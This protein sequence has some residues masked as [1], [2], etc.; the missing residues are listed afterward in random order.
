MRLIS[1]FPAGLRSWILALSSVLLLLAAA[2]G[3]GQRPPDFEVTLY[4]GTQFRLSDQI[5]ESS[6]VLN[7]WYPTCPP[8]REEMPSLQ[9]A[10]THLQDE[11]VRFLGL[12][13]PQGFDTEQDAKDFIDELGLTFD[14]ATD[15]RASIALDYELEVYPKTYFINKSGR[16]STSR[17]STLDTE[18]IIRL[19]RE[20]DQG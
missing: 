9:E 20:M 13:V 8:C 16:L 19:V 7:F 17:I 12:F 2:C 3:G 18:E 1:L 5:D 10:W 6:V 11:D 4:D 14:F 15:R